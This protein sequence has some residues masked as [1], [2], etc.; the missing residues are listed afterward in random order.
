MNR[1]R[2]ELIK[3]AATAAAGILL[4]ATT[5]AAGRRS[6]AAA[7]APE[8]RR[9]TWAERLGGSFTV[10]RPDGRRIELRLS[11]VTDLASA[12]SAR[13]VGHERAFSVLFEGSRRSALTQGT[14]DVWGLGHGS[15]SVFLVPVDAPGRV[16]RYEAVFNNALS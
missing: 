3:A 6:G 9:S 13:L 12:P 14:Y 2:R 8:T 7:G 15:I 1:S 4:P 16:Q 10:E 5:Y 11:S